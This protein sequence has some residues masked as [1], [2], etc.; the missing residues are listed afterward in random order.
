MIACG[1]LFLLVATW[2]TFAG[3]VMVSLIFAL[4]VNAIARR[5]TAL[6]VTDGAVRLGS[7][8][9]I[10]LA[11]LDAARMR[12]GHGGYVIDLESGG[13]RRLT[14][15]EGAELDHESATWLARRLSQLIKA[16]GDGPR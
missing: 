5:R 14:V 16:A 3:T 9:A 4:A 10:P 7:S 8:E 1:A 11:S 13:L 12:E 6:T 2:G 15:G